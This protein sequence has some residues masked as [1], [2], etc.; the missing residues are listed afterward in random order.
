MIYCF[1]PAKFFLSFGFRVVFL[2]RNGTE[3]LLKP[4]S[5]FLLCKA[6]QT[7]QH[8]ITS[9]L[10]LIPIPH[11][12]TTCKPPDLWSSECKGMMESCWESDPGP[13]TEKAFCFFLNLIYVTLWQMFLMD[14][15]LVPPK[16]SEFLLFGF[17]AEH[18][19][20]IVQVPY[21][22]FWSL[23]GELKPC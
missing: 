1:K 4:R 6:S 14:L 22:F 5:W 17:D 3:L 21:G 23:T 10:T 2:N 15:T 9:A 20:F 13:C 16:K 8:Y 11:R 7:N 19:P 12:R 18:I